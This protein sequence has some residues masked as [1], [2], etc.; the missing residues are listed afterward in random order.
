MTH[1]LQFLQYVDEIIVLSKGRVEAIG[2]YHDIQKSGLNIVQL[3]TTP[4]EDS[5]DAESKTEVPPFKFNRSLMTSSSI[6]DFD[7]RPSTISIY[8]QE[9]EP[10]D[11]SIEQDEEKGSKGSI[12]L[13]IY[14]KYFTASGGC[15]LFYTVAFLCI[16]AQAFAS[17]GD[18]YLNYW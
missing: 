2:S 13:K 8:N 14:R 17:S 10:E 7:R 4:I 3:I 11:S 6:F 12:G 5:N 1:Q 15:C 18:F 16:A 9:E